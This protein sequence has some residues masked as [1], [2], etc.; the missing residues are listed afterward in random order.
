MGDVRQWCWAQGRDR[1]VAQG[2]MAGRHGAVG[3][4]RKPERGLG[5]LGGRAG[6]SGHGQVRLHTLRQG[7]TGIRPCAR[8]ETR[9]EGDEMALRAEFTLWF[10]ACSWGAHLGRAGAERCAFAGMISSL[11]RPVLW[12]RACR[13]PPKR[14]KV[15]QWHTHKGTGMAMRMIQCYVQGPLHYGQ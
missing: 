2:L 13:F 11:G 8:M 14:Q 6:V 9:D 5:A 1:R 4:R 3:I 10:S 12:I 7:V 15:A